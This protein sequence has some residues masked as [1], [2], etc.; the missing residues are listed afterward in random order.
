M[1]TKHIFLVETALMLSFVVSARAEVSGCYYCNT[2]AD[3]DACD[4]P[5][6]TSSVR[7]QLCSN[8]SLVESTTSIESSTSNSSEFLCTT[9]T[10][11][12]QDGR[13]ITSRGCQSRNISATAVCTYLT[14]AASSTG[15][16]S[17][18]ACTSCET[19]LC[20]SS[21]PF[22]FSS[23][24]LIMGILITLFKDF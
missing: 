18:F 11:N 22:N 1:S 10:Y 3:G 5:L 15:Y 7:I 23:A 16:T 8:S 6:D 24:L 2:D 17:N 13:Y 19:D 4:T 20:N 12:A 9:V 21:A 14:L